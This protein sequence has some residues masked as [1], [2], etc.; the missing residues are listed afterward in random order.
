MT[1]TAILAVAAAAC[2]AA[3]SAHLGAVLVAAI[4]V[5]WIWQDMID[6]AA[7]AAQK[8]AAVVPT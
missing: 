2:F 1:A 4:G 6:E 3:K 5:V 8:R 7:I